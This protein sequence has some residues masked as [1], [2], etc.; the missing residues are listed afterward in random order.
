MFFALTLPLFGFWTTLSVQ[1]HCL[2]CLFG[3]NLVRLTVTVDSLTLL[4]LLSL[5]ELLSFVHWLLC[6]TWQFKFAFDLV[7]LHL[8]LILGLLFTLHWLVFIA[9]SHLVLL[10]W[11]W[12][13]PTLLTVSC[14]SSISPHGCCTL[15]EPA[16]RELP[17]C[18]FDRSRAPTASA[19]TLLWDQ[20]TPQ[21]CLNHTH[22]LQALVHTRTRLSQI[23]LLVLT[24]A[25]GIEGG[26]Q[27]QLPF[28]GEPEHLRTKLFL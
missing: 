17:L 24:Q 5:L 13:I 15:R 4:S 27:S 23:L 9:T 18:A 21:P 12:F 14:S 3:W 6:L 19:L 2:Y 8:A 16:T 10:V 26:F 11:L 28:Q 7:V 25:R 22:Q 20:S 1:T